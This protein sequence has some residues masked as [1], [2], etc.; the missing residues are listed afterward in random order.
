MTAAASPFD[1]KDFVRNLSSAPGVYRMI[2]ADEAVLYV[3]KASALR[4]RVG[5]YFNNTPKSA[6]IASMFSRVQL[7]GMPSG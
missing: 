1:P 5:S 7:V 2:G 6:R 4:N 3:G